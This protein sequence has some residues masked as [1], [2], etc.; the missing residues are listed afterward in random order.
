MIV[1]PVVPVAG[2]DDGVD[3]GTLPSPLLRL[4]RVLCRFMV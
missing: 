2:R 4:V 3:D 1:I